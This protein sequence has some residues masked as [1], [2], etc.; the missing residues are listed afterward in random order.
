M[1]NYVLKQNAS[2][3]Y[4]FLSY[5]MHNPELIHAINNNKILDCGAGGSIPPLILFYQNGFNCSGIDIS[6]E[7][8]ELARSF[9]SEKDIPIQFT[10][11]DMRSMPFEDAEFDFVFEHYSMCHLTKADTKK[12]I[13]EM[14]RV[15]KNGGFA[16]LGVISCETWPLLGKEI[17]PG[18]WVQAE[19][20][21]SVTHS[22]FTDEDAD[23]LVSDWEI[24]Q[25]EKR[26]LWRTNQIDAIN[27]QDWI[28]MF[29]KIG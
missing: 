11:A 7:S 10:H 13:S 15:L 16:Y 23:N 5:I 1:N 4:N 25:K 9:C 26:V 29:S 19:N 14:K 3:I 8:L 21:N 18:E 24:L 2:P 20:G 17:C 6:I 28:K 27:E 12:A 22:F